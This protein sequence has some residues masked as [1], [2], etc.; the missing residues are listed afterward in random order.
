VFPGRFRKE[1]SARFAKESSSSLRGASRAPFVSR[2]FL[3][4]L[5]SDLTSLKT[6][7]SASLLLAFALQFLRLSLGRS[8]SRER[9]CGGA[10]EDANFCKAKGKER[11]AQKSLAPY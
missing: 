6:S 8:A 7:H 11:G 3:A 1:R 5:S 4:F 2:A 10:N 9:R